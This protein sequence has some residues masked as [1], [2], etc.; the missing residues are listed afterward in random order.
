[1][2][3]IEQIRAARALLDWSQQ[4]LAEHADLS[5]TGIARI[6][7]GTNKPN[8]K[9]LKKIEAAFDRANIEFIGTSGL[10]KR[11][12]QINI[13]NGPEEFVKFLIKVYEDLREVPE[14]ER[15]VVVNNVS[16]D[17]FIKWEGDYVQTHQN[18]M[19]EIKARYR[20]IVQEGDTNFTADEYANYRWLNKE[21]FNSISYYIYGDTAALINFKADTVR[22]YAIHSKDIAEF[23]KRE[24]DSV[25]SETTDPIK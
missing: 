2:L 17:L 19:N 21:K 4:D 1:M 25:W 23:Y 10:R 24:F 13:Y 20:I 9:T 6:E 11:S 12:G 18:R 22:V 3:T 7:N 16:E 15:E 5:Q 8:S 14:N